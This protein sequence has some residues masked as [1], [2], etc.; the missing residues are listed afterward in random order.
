VE[1]G[2]DV[3]HSAGAI[4]H[5]RLDPGTMREKILHVEDDPANRMLVRDLLEFHGYEV[6]EAVD[7]EA[8]LVAAERER[9]DLILMDVQLPNISGLE[10][11]RR[12]KAGA[13]RQPIPIIVVTSLAS[14]GTSYRDAFA[15]GCDAYLGKP[16]KPSELLRLIQR[17]L[18][19]GRR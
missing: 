10:A 16:Y 5:D 11:M 19:P 1:F 9:P 7:G 4:A 17:F 3:R 6:V 15:A 8:A 13:Q 14:S 18:P 12:I 2:C